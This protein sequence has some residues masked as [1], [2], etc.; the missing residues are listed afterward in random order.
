MFLKKKHCGWIK[1]HGCADGRKQHIYK[2]KEK[3]SMPMVSVESLF[4]SFVIDAKEEHRK[5]VPC[6]AFMQVDIDE[7]LHVK[8]EGPL[9][10]LLMKVDPE[11]YSKFLCQENGKDKMYVH[12]AK[13]LY[14]TLQAAMLFWKD[15]SGYLILEGFTLNLYDNCITNKVIVGMQC[16]V[17][18]HVNNLKMSHV[19]DHI[20]DELV[21]QL[22][23]HYGKIAPLTVM[24][25]AQGMTHDY[26]SS[27]TLDYG[28][29]GKVM[30]CMDDYMQDL[31]DNKAPED[32]AGM[33]TTLAGNHLH[34]HIWMMPPQSCSTI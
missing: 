10:T 13:A 26:L 33:A 29:L 3:T 31:L 4:L 19:A 27:M 28:V 32:M 12:L 17:L 1:G 23:G 8:L 11:L 34:Q 24:Q 16:T 20:L 7:V 2:T 15:L 5:V 18:W 6:G 25:G 21:D 22:N 30:I 9:A 14:G